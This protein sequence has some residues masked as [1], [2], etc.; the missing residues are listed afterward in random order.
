MSMLDHKTTA[1]ALVLVLFGCDDRSSTPTTDSTGPTGD[2]GQT[3]KDLVVDTRDAG[4]DLQDAGNDI[5]D[6]GVD[7]PICAAGSTKAC[8]T[9]NAGICAAGKQTC[10]SA[11][12][13]PCSATVKPGD[14]AEVC[15][16][17]KDEDCDGKT[18][19]DDTDCQ[20]CTPS[21]SQACKT[22]NPGV[23]ASGKQTCTLTQGSWDWGTCLAPKPGSQSEVCGSTKDE[24]CDGKTDGDDTDC[25]K[26]TPSATKAC[27][28][29]YPGVCNP[30][31]IACALAKGTWDWGACAATVKPGDRS[32]VC[33][34]TKDDD[35]DG[36]TDTADLDCPACTDKK[37]NGDETDV[38]CGGSTCPACA[39]GKQC[40]VVKDCATGLGCCNG[41]CASLAT[42]THCGACGNACPG[43]T[44]CTSG[45][46]TCPSNMAKKGAACV[47]D[48]EGTAPAS[49]WTWNKNKSCPYAGCT[50]TS[51]GAT[52]KGCAKCTTVSTTACGNLGWKVVS[53]PKSGGGKAM[54][55]FSHATSGNCWQGDPLHKT[56]SIGRVINTKKITL[57]VYIAGAG[58]GATWQCGNLNIT[59]LKAGKVVGSKLY[60]DAVYGTHP[61]SGTVLKGNKQDFTF[62]LGTAIGDLD[63]DAIKLWLHKYSCVSGHWHTFTVDDIILQ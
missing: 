48:F 16:S 59:L 8:T 29:T 14:Q 42:A 22:T 2:T 34:N 37:K 58:G 47:E 27:S 38:D 50:S 55:V 20:K 10:T 49:G 41:T 6:V 31:T 25:Q 62:N 7:M 57:K 30:G 19:G 1:L 18:D 46:C 5:H 15:G 54:Q 39:A 26:C 12:W 61:C 44:A 3:I 17:T 45:K 13:G 53:S 9:T 60:K 11:G 40:K 28:T 23:C 32:E 56:Y 52:C 24:D 36:K 21:A 33:D 63:F 35:C 4:D 43:V 51:T